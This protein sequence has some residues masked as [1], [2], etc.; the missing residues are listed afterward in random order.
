MHAPHPP[1]RDY[2]MHEAER[3]GWVRQLFD[4]TAGDYDRIERVMALGSGSWYRKQALRRA[5]LVPGMRV[6]DIGVG[7]G[8]TARQAALLA[9][10][11]GKVTGIDP[12][13]GMIESAKVPTA[14]ELL[15]GN[16][17]SIPAD[18]ASADFLSMGYALRHIA[19]LSAAF[20]EFMRVLKP[21]GRI[22]LL[23][24]TRPEG[25]VPRAVLKA[26]MRGVVPFLAGIVG[27]NAD[28]PTL[29]RYYWDTID[30]CATPQAILSAIR[31]AGFVDEHRRVEL[32]IFS[33]YCA[34]K[35]LTSRAC[36]APHQEQRQA[37]Q[38]T[39]K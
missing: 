7:T 32:G 38:E 36:E 17:Q 16:A 6:L 10:P 12:S 24:I 9:G 15:L 20:T 30:A 4:R 18:S 35:P 25:R 8:L 28:S 26:Y 14:V 34:R 2:Y 23:E 13:I 27:H 39:Q 21:G 5:G 1:L 19:D 33:E 31:E 22:C 3:G 29:M 37:Q 11:S